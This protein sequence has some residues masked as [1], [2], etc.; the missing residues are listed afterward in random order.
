MTEVATL[1]QAL[2]E[3]ENRAAAERTERWKQEA[4]VE[5]VQKELQ[6]LVKKHESLELDSKTQVSELAAALKSAKSAKAE[7]QKA[8]QEIEAM[9]NIAAGKAFIMQSK[10]VKV[11]YLL[12]T[13]VRSSAGAFTDLPRSAFDAAAYYRAEEGSSMEKVFWSQYAEAG[14]LV[15]LSDQLKQMVELHK[16]AEHAI[17][18]FIVRLWPGEALPGSYFGLVRRLVDACPRLEVIKCSVCIEGARRALAHA[19]VHWGKMDAEK[20]VK[21]GPPPGKEHRV[22]EAYYE[23]V[24]KGARLIADECSKDVI[25]E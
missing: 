13:R 9:K 17:K 25:F 8:L 20:L 10:H 15:P 5:E 12:L 3:A 22:P 1:K 7:A 21:D 19:K 6:A 16:V 24:L 18:G 14:H 2:S 23:S 11:N 4:R